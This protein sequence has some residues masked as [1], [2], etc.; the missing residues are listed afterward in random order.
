MES[1][2]PRST[3]LLLHGFAGSPFEMRELGLRLERRGF[4]V[5]MPAWPGH[6]TAPRDLRSVTAEHYFE[7]AES[8]WDD[9]ARES[10]R[11]YV[12]GL[13]MGGAL[14]LYLAGRRPLAGLV[15][16][17]TPVSVAPLVAGGVPLLERIAP[18][19]HVPSR[20]GPRL[21]GDEGYATTPIASVG[22]FLSVIE[23]VRGQLAQVTC[24]LL[25]VHSLHD[26]TV[27]V[28]NARRIYDGVA[29]ADRTLYIIKQGLHLLTRPQYVGFIEPAI[30]VFLARL[31]QGSEGGTVE[32][33]PPPNRF[34]P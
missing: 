17:S 6:A 29:S 33:S 12:V 19:L 34:A 24:P 25:V 23:R 20:I 22:V 9:A 32:P 10:E 18:G 2:T 26:P 8:V 1:R 16:I 13:S 4:A 28:E 3:I 30:G 15:T 5:R 7:T 21:S 27:P 31:E 11:V 14:G